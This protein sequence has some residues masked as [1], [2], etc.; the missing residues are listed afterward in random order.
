MTLLSLI[1]FCCSQFRW[2]ARVSLIAIIYLKLHLVLQCHRS[3]SLVNGK[4]VFIPFL[5]RDYCGSYVIRVYEV[6]FLQNLEPYVRQHV[7]WML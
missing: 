6:L 7:A 2:F 3:S 1:L 4:E 5:K